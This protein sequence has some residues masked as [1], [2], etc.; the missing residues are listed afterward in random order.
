M[1]PTSRKS[2]VRRALWGFASAGGYGSNEDDT[3]QDKDPRYPYIDAGDG[4]WEY[5]PSYGDMKHLN[6]FFTTKGIEYW[7]MASNNRLLS[8]INQGARTYLL[9]EPGRQYVA[10]VANSGSFAILLPEG[11]YYQYLFD[12]TSGETKSLGTIAGG[13]L[14]TFTMPTAPR[15]DADKSNDW[16]LHLS[17]FEEAKNETKGKK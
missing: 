8:K 9:A 1:P 4:N 13:E 15:A 2:N 3:D 17:T 16:V 10:Y 5:V 12:P 6:E 14:R 7:K 11:T